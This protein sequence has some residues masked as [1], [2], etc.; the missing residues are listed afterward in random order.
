MDYFITKED[1]VDINELPEIF[2]NGYIA[3]V[4]GAKHETKKL[5]ENKLFELINKLNQPILVEKSHFH[6][7]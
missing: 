2:H 3:L 4:I 7:I 1:K 6:H 5:P